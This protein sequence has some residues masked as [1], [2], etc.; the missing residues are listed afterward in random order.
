MTPPLF[1]IRLVKTGDK[2]TVENHKIYEG[3]TVLGYTTTLPAV[4]KRFTV[5]R[6][7]RNGVETPGIMETSEVIS[8]GAFH[9]D[10]DLAA[11]VI[12]SQ[13]LVFETENS[14]YGI[15]FLPEIT[16]EKSTP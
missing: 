1:H 11:G 14:T 4:G 5:L 6:Y 3:Y 2:G 12:K 9:A 7:N 10:V 8:L 13:S 15:D 16:E